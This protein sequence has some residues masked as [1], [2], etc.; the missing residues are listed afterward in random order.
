MSIFTS[1]IHI[2]ECFYLF[3]FD[4]GSLYIALTVQELTN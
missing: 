2:W 1:V 3:I 4:M